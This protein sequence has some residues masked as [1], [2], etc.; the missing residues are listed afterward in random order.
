MLVISGEWLPDGHDWIVL[1]RP[2]GCTIYLARDP[3]SG[4]IAQRVHSARASTR[5]LYGLVSSGGL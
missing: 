3:R 2:D 5:R 4:R 1:E